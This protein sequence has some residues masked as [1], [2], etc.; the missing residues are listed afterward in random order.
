[1]SGKWTKME[2]RALSGGIERSLWGRLALSVAFA[3]MAACGA[4]A[5]EVTVDAGV[6]RTLT[7]EEANAIIAS[8]EDVV[9]RGEGRFIIGR[10]LAGYKGSIRVEGGYLRCLA[11]NALG[12]CDVRYRREC[13]RYDGVARQ[14]RRRHVPPQCP[15]VRF[16]NG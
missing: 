5:L 1:M 13:W 9:K 14:D 12:D 11:A 3:C 10:S 6:D 4:S 7:D 8:G 16:G 15:C 2:R